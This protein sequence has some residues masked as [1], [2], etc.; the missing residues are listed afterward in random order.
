MSKSNTTENDVLVKLFQ[1]TELSWEANTNLYVSLHDAD[2]TE[3]GDQTSHEI[4]YTAPYVRQTVAR[5]TSGWDVVANVASNKAQISFPT[6]T[7]GTATATYVAVGTLAS[8]A[9]QIL[10]SGPC[11]SLAISN[12]IQPQFAIGALTITED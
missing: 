9:G 1:K 2:P 8:G 11:T 7:G 6:C 5:S 3:S 12:G 4:A 10:Y